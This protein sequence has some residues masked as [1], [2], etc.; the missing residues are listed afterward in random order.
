MEES[1][2]DEKCCYNCK[3][4]NDLLCDN[5]GSRIYVEHEKD[6]FC[7]KYEKREE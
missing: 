6:T 1:C 2:S 4:N 7:D 5:Y 3:W